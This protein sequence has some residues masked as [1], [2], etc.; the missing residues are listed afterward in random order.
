M[1]QANDKI[2]GKSRAALD[3]MHKTDLAAAYDDIHGAGSSEGM[4]KS[5]LVDALVT[6]G[7]SRSSR[8][9]GNLED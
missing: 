3:V 6:H 1:G 4:L 8:Y 7:K 2:K 9:W 5:E